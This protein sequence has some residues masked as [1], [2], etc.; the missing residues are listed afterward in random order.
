LHSFKNGTNIRVN[1]ERDTL[2]FFPSVNVIYNLS[3]K[4]LLRLA[5]GKT[6]NRPEFREMAPYYFVDFNLNAGIYGNDSIKQAYVNSYDIRYEFYPAPDETFSLGLFY[7]RFTNAIEFTILGN[8]PTQYSFA[9][10]KTAYS[11]GLEVELKEN[12]EFLGLRNFNVLFNGSL[13]KSKIQAGIGDLSRNRPLQGQS[14]YIVN[15]GVFYQSDVNGLMVNLIYNIIGKRIVAVGRP[16][17]DQWEDIPDIYES[18]RNLF[19]LTI[20][21]KIGRF[22]EIKGGVKDLL[23]QKVEFA[24]YVKTDVDM[25]KYGSDGIK[26][27]ERKQVTKLYYPGRIFSLGFTVSL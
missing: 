12:L 21:K 17:S 15:A 2:N 3:E 22:I 4:N 8:N 26:H 5:Y 23:N 10:V 9:N 1:P 24:Q 20:S 14:P 6:V 11:F 25:S 19:D 16:S 13:I 7:K 18:P 27:F